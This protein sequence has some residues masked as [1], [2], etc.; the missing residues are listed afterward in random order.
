MW[1]LSARPNGD[2]YLRRLCGEDDRRG[3]DALVASLIAG[4]A[5]LVRQ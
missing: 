1:N 5:P 2:E 4:L 3:A